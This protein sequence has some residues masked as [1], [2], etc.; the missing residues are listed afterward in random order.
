[1]MSFRRADASMRVVIVEDD[2]QLRAALAMI[3]NRMGVQVLADLPDGQAALELLAVEQ[4]DLILTD[5]QM[6]KLDGIT[7]VRRLR[8]R[9]DRTPIIM[10]SGQHEQR[11][12]QLAF[13]AGV[14]HYLCKPLSTQVLEDTIGQTFPGWAA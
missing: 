13:S 4:P 14:T 7:L 9:G 6:P 12:Q 10:I 5:C 3:L 2:G 8:A 1:M 11:I